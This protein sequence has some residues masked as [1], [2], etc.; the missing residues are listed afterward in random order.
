M[1]IDMWMI[2]DLLYI[3][4]YT[5]DSEISYTSFRNMLQMGI[6][7]SA[8]LWIMYG[9]VYMY[10]YIYMWICLPT[11]TYKHC[12]NDYTINS[13]VKPDENGYFVWF[14]SRSMIQTKI[15]YITCDNGY[16]TRWAP[17]W[18]VCLCV[19]VETGLVPP[20]VSIHS[21]L[22]CYMLII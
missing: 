19:R 16:N 13:N 18:N 17:Q 2:Y 9:Y 3:Y 15:M 1:N 6:S 11:C 7:N 5:H 14:S 10:T 4:I 20:K 21:K 8:Y 22:T 12:Y